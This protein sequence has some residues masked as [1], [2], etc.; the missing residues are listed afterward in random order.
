[1]N[2]YSLVGINFSNIANNDKLIVDKVNEYSLGGW[3]LYQFTTG[4][5]TSN[6]ME[7]P[8]R[9]FLS[10][11]PFLEKQSNNRSGIVFGITK[12]IFHLL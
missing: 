11:A 9:V 12:F 7:I 10:R 8:A 5:S 6:V 2:F 4:S 1:M 3:E